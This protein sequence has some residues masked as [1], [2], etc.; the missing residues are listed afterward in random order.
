MMHH[1]VI[2]NAIIIAA[3]AITIIIVTVVI[4][5]TATATA[6]ATLSIYTGVGTFMM[7]V[8]C[9]HVETSYCIPV[10][11]DLIFEYLISPVGSWYNICCFRADLKNWIWF[12]RTHVKDQNFLSQVFFLKIWARGM[13]QLCHRQRN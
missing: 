9:I 13:S 1:R 7:H 5:P 11:Q 12:F 6:T 8:H 10:C 2:I 3:V 4:I